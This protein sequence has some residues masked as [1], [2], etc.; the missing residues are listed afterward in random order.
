MMTEKKLTTAELAKQVEDAKKIFERLNE[1]LQ[2]Q[3][4]EEEDQ[5]QAELALKKAER[6]KEVDDAFENCDRLIRAYIKDY[7]K[8][9]ITT[10][11]D[12]F[13]ENGRMLPWWF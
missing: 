1:Q 8:Y 9:S 12:D 10:D 7:G 11:T 5:K 2:R 4:Q 3:K 6:K 13:I